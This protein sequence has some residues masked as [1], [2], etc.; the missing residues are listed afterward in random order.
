MMNRQLRNASFAI[1]S[2]TRMS[3]TFACNPHNATLP[4]PCKQ[5]DSREMMTLAALD[6]V[7]AAINDE[8]TA[9]RLARQGLVFKLTA[10]VRQA[11]AGPPPPLPPRTKDGAEGDADADAGNPGAKKMLSRFCRIVNKRV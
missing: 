2:T 9:S 5:R 10:I 1:P 11:T 6:V 4:P 7:L 3:S 8:N